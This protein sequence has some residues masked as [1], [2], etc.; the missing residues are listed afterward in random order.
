MADSYFF[1]NK[2]LH[3]SSILQY[4]VKQKAN[5]MTQYP[6]LFHEFK[7]RGY[8]HSLKNKTIYNNVYLFL[9]RNN[10]KSKKNSKQMNGFIL[11]NSHV[12]LK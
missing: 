1:S 3:E 2:F 7:S 6:E 11:T 9:Y 8:P 10:F 5:Q 12:H 4:A